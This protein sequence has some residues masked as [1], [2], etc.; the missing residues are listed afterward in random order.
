MTGPIARPLRLPAL[1]A[2]ALLAGACGGSGSTP[3]PASAAA[4]APAASAPAES[5]SAAPAPGGEESAVRIADFAFDPASLTVTAGSTVT[6]TNGDAAPH[7][8]TA[9]DGSFDTGSIGGGA[10]ASQAFPDA[11]TFTYHCAIHPNMTGTITVE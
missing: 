1:L 4:S 3:A 5:Q 10:S 6:W 11:G 2:I 7:T 8:A 9:D